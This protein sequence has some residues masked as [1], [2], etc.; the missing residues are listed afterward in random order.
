MCITRQKKI[1]VFQSWINLLWLHHHML[2]FKN[3]KC[4]ENY[5]QMSEHDT[6]LLKSWDLPGS[7]G[8][9]PAAARRGYGSV[10]LPGWGHA[11]GPLLWRPLSGYRNWAPSAAGRPIQSSGQSSGGRCAGNAMQRRQKTLCSPPHV[12]K[13]QRVERE[14]TRGKN[15]MSLNQR[16]EDESNRKRGWEV[17]RASEESVPSSWRKKGLRATEDEEEPD[18]LWSCRP[19]GTGHRAAC[20]PQ[21]GFVWSPPTPKEQQRK[22]GTRLPFQGYTKAVGRFN[23]ASQRTAGREKKT[24]N[25]SSSFHTC[26]PE[27]SLDT[28]TCAM[29]TPSR[30]PM[31]GH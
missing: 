12:N 13:L 24:W 22:D 20:W 31:R 9:G 28:R 25:A 17:H 15:L 30:H 18:L 14:M 2:F 8:A 23:S 4:T 11:G 26:A 6:T 27:Y 3:F 7:Q 29:V 1:I 10:F 5:K 19:S 21:P 16:N